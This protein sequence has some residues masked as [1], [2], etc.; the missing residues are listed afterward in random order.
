MVVSFV[1]FLFTRCERLLTHSFAAL[2][3]PLVI[4]HNLWIKIVRTRQPWSNL[5]FCG[6]G[7]HL[8]DLK[9]FFLKFLSHNFF[10]ENSKLYCGRNLPKNNVKS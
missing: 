4:F 6:V 3:L 7:T 5:Y 9:A 8:N 1:R 10:R 2:T